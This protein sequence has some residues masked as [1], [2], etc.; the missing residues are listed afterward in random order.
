MKFHNFKPYAKYGLSLIFIISLVGT[1]YADTNSHSIKSLNKPGGIALSWDDTGHI[2]TCYQYLSM[3]QKYNATCTMNVNNV[4]KFKSIRPQTLINELNVLHSAGWE[5]ASHGYGHVNSVQFLNT[6]TSTPWLNQEIFPNIVEI[7][8]YGYPVYTFAYPYSSRNATTDA[9]LAPYFRT[10]RTRAPQVV[11]GNV[12]ETTL[13]YYNWDDAQLLYGIEIDDQSGGCSLQSIENGIDY[14]IKTGSV[15]VLYG[16]VI[17][18]NVTGPYQ[19]STFRLDSILNYTSH[20]GGVFYHMGDL[21][22]SSWVQIPKFSNVTSNYTVSTNSLLAGKNVTFVDYSINQNAELLDFDDGSPT[23]STANVTHTYTIP[24][25]YKANL[26]VTNDVSSDSMLQTITVIQPIPVASFT[27]NSI[28]GFRP[29]NIAFTDTSTGFPTSWSWDFGDGNTSTSQ[30]PVYEYSNVGN[31]SV[32]LTVANDNGS[33]YAQKVNYITV[34]PQPPSP[35]FSLNITSGNIPLTVQF[36][37][38]STGSP[39]SWN[40]DFGDGYTSTER[41]PTHT[42]STAGNY[43]VSLTVSNANG[44]ASKAAT[45]DVL[46]ES[47]SS[48]GSDNGGSSRDGSDNGGSSSGGRS[49]GGGGGGGAGGSPEPQSNVE[50]KELSQAFITSGKVVKFD[51]PRNA[52]SVIYVSFD[53]KKTAGKTTT[54]IET[55][56]GKS[57]LVSGLPSGEIYKSFNIWVGNSGFATPKNIENA[58]VFFKV[59]KSWIQNQKID[60]SSIT[61][62]RYN[63]TKWNSLPTCLLREDD[64]YVYFT[65]E[66]PGFS[67]FTITGKMT[68]S[69]AGIQPATGTKT[70]PSSV[71]ETQTKLNTENTTANVEQTPEQKQSPKTSGKGNTSIPGFDMVCGMVSL[72]A[73]LLHKRK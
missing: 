27:S 46:D 25:I 23:S 57:T 50:T 4:N 36:N 24:G 59:E 12:N 70:Q 68:A 7:T 73:V 60:Q 71:N 64:K 42:Y 14:A 43:S 52:T 30:N 34:L 5:I 51:F 72:L 11:N 49:S 37:D 41:N 47:R 21:G 15:L 26:T 45:I 61:L 3:F 69:G 53:S 58:V 33:N 67:P 63:D 20:N 39:T 55:L 54:I 29:L 10:L 56:K 44:I 31:Y 35:N 9:A 32:T 1:A 19:T 48:D 65:A 40:W 38:T 18:P 16:H 13:A 66:T 6:N 2:D 22:N 28:I 17:T 62:N 8:R